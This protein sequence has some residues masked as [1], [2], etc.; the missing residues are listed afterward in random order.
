MSCPYLLLGRVVELTVK[1]SRT[2]RQDAFALVA[3]RTWSSRWSAYKPFPAIFTNLD[4]SQAKNSN[5]SSLHQSQPRRRLLKYSIIS[6]FL[7]F[8]KFV[9]LLLFFQFFVQD[10]QRVNQTARKALFIYNLNT[11]INTHSFTHRNSLQLTH[12]R[13]STPLHPA[14]RRSE[15]SELWWTADHHD[16]DGGGDEQ[17]LRSCSEWGR[18]E[19]TLC[20]K[21]PGCLWRSNVVV[22]TSIFPHLRQ[23]EL[24]KHLAQLLPITTTRKHQLRKKPKWEW[25]ERE[26]MKRTDGQSW[27]KGRAWPS[28][29]SMVHLV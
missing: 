25:R 2:R 20:N 3:V 12:H 15:G 7:C 23:L 14:W 4:W 26:M 10:T 5:L 8:G 28:P 13:S 22:M 21:A 1:P 24:G 16:G 19:L 27:Q 6:F 9:L 11:R 29:C 18:L 17:L